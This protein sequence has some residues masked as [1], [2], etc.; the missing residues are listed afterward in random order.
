M[1]LIASWN[2]NSITVRLETVLSWL[3]N[4][5]PDVLCLQETKIVDGK[6]PALA[7]QELGYYAE[8][9]GQPTY[10]GVC[11]LAKSL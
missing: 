1:V 7:F 8:F 4:V 11:I 2:V 9:T 6:F 10:N 5:Q 3:A